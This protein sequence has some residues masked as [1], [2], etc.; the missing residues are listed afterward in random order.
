[1]RIRS[2][3][4]AALVVAVVLACGAGDDREELS[5]PPVVIAQVERTMLIVCLGRM[6]AV[7]S[8]PSSRW[9]E[10]DAA[11]SSDCSM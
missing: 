3:L 2:T 11:R 9:Q 5:A 8:K 10:Q 6:C 1:M 7:R 4:W